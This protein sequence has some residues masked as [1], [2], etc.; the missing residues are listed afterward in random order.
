MRNAKLFLEVWET[1]VER[2]F[3]SDSIIFRLQT[4]L[5]VTNESYSIYL[6]R[7]LGTYVYFYF[8]DWWDNVGTPLTRSGGVRNPAAFVT[9]MKLQWERSRQFEAVYL[10]RLE[11][12]SHGTHSIET[13]TDHWVL[14][15]RYY[16]KFGEPLDN[17]IQKSMKQCRALLRR[18]RWV[19]PS[20]PSCG[21]K[22]LRTESVMFW[23]VHKHS[24]NLADLVWSD[25]LWKRET[26][27]Q[28]KNS[29]WSFNWVLGVE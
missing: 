2:W 3:P 27:W 9:P 21:S 19:I 17:W 15:R 6:Y 25:M 13:L 24:I 20:R 29:A 22:S 28:K 26:M 11:L 14:L 18:P 10:S 7:C 5:S 4:K 1:I 16:R 12:R 8:Y 23:Q